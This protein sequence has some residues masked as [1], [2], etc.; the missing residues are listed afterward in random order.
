M[1]L[2]AAAIRLVERNTLPR[3]LVCHTPK[4]RKWVTRSPKVDPRWFP[5]DHL[6]RDSL[7]FD[8]LFGGGPDDRMLRASGPD[9]WF[10]KP[11]AAEIPIKEQTVRMHI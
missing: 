3:F 4:G 7:A 10:D 9:A 5:M 11:W 6:D 1:S 2:T 8:V